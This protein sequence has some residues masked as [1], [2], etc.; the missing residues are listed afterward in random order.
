MPINRLPEIVIFNATEARITTHERPNLCIRNLNW[1]LILCGVHPNRLEPMAVD[2][3]AWTSSCDSG[4]ESN[5][6][7][8]M[9]GGKIFVINSLQLLFRVT[10]SACPQCHRSCLNRSV[11]VSYWLEWETMCW[12]WRNMNILDRRCCHLWWTDISWAKLLKLPPF[13]RIVSSAL[14]IIGCAISKWPKV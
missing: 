3:K 8:Y 1:S 14:L 13:Y 5:E 9:K 11:L 10:F 7:I 4:V 2:Q 6:I 12:V